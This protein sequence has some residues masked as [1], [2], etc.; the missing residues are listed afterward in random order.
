M[1]KQ[2]ELSENAKFIAEKRY[3]KVDKEG[4]PLETPAQ[5]FRRIAEFIA[6]GETDLSDKKPD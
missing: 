5:M 6:E 2:V 1:N 4:K 3:L